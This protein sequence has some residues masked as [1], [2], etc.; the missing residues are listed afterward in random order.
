VLRCRDGSRN[1]CSLKEHRR[2]ASPW[3]VPV[4]PGVSRIPSRLLSYC[5]EKP[6]GIKRR[7]PFQHGVYSAPELLGEDGQGFGFAVPADQFLM[8]ELGRQI[9]S[10][11]QAGCLAE[12]PFQM[13]VSD[14]VV[15][16]GLALA[17]RFMGALHQPGI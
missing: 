12:G 4:R 10:K 6:L 2:R 3:A 17:C 9:L 16:D 15:W 1:R 13:D 7:P 11:E 14:L 8:I 5:F